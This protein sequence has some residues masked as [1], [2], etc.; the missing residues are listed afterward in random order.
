MRLGDE[1]AT[2]F[3]LR[4]T[5]DGATEE[6]VL[7]QQDREV[8]RTVRATNPRDGSVEETVR[9]NGALTATRTYDGAMRL[10]S[11]ETP[12]ERRV[13]RYRAGRL[14]SLE[15]SD[16][17][18]APLYRERYGYTSRGT[19]R[20]ADRSYPDG[21]RLISSFLFAGDR[22]RAERLQAQPVVLTARYDPSG[23][24]VAESERSG[25]EVVWERAHTYDAASGRL[26]ET[27]EKHTDYMLR[28]VYDA[29]GRVAQENRTGT[30]A[31][32][33]T[34]GYDGEGRVVRLR[35]V[36]STGTEEWQTEYDAQGDV[37][38]EIY[39]ARGRLQRVRVYTGEREWH[40]DLYRDG[41]PVL[42]VLYR[43][44]QKAGEERLP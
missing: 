36:G 11:E 42:R 21:S 43:D 44:D 40:D 26:A 30:G 23:R 22:L 15:V 10:I 19:L 7:L 13:Y 39:L 18:G 28:R 27:T 9:E 8:R 5:T 29:E 16:P 4:V 38:R 2:G 25:D 34:Y 20:E 31:Y 41:R 24:I 12:E 6:A 35:R 37:A 33:S 1:P 14:E 17:D 3:V 32:R